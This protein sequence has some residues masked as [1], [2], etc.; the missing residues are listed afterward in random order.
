MEIFKN[1]KFS[2]IRFSIGIMYTFHNSYVTLYFW[3]FGKF[4]NT[5]TFKNSFL[6][7]IMY[8]FHNS[9]LKQKNITLYLYIYLYSYIFI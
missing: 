6:L 4:Q 7:G 8:T 1:Q 9:Y 3:D 2:K 5:K